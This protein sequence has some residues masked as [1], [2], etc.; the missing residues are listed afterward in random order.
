MSAFRG[1]TVIGRQDRTHI[2]PS[3]LP[4]IWNN[5][6][7]YDRYQATA[8]SPGLALGFVHRQKPPAP[9]SPEY[10]E[11]L[12]GCSLRW[13]LDDKLRRLDRENIQEDDALAALRFGRI[14]RHRSH[15]GRYTARLG[16]L[17]VVLEPLRPCNISCI[18]AYYGRP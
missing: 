7:A 3:A 11:S 10:M 13:L 16:R 2:S 8:K 6:R 4:L 1:A 9:A 12:R 14:K 18:T 17:T 15:R 5:Q